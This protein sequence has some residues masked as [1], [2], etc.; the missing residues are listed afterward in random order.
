MK[1]Y[2]YKIHHLTLQ[3]GKSSDEQVLDALNQ[4]GQEGWRLNRVYGELS[5]RALKSWKGALNFL[6]E[7]ELID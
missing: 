7:R 1:R 5:L 4:F 6:L 3:T 2:E